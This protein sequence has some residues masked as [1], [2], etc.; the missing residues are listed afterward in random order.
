M[1]VDIKSTKQETGSRTQNSTTTLD[2]SISNGRSECLESFENCGNRQPEIERATSDGSFSGPFVPPKGTTPA[3]TVSLM[4]SSACNLKPKSPRKK[5]DLKRKSVTDEE[6]NKNK[7]FV[8]EL[9]GG[10]SLINKL[11]KYGTESKKQPFMVA[12]QLTFEDS[13]IVNNGND[14]EDE[15]TDSTISDEEMV[16]TNKTFSQ[17]FDFQNGTSATRSA[18]RVGTNRRTENLVSRTPTPTQQKYKKGDIVQ[19]PNGIRKKFNGKQWRRL[20]SREGCNKESQRRGYC[21]RHLSQKGRSIKTTSIPG[22]KKGKIKGKG[23]IEW[24][25]GGDSEG[26]VEE[27]CSPKGDKANIGNK[28]VEAAAMLM[29]LSSSRCATPFSNPTTPLPLSPNIGHSQS[30]S[31]FSYYN[32]GHS[33][34]APNPNR[35][36]TPVRNWM[37]SAVPRS[38]RSSSTELLSPFCPVTS[39]VS[40]AVSPDS[41]IHCRDDSASLT[42]N[43]P[44]LISPLPSLSPH[45]PTKRTFSPISPPAGSKRAFSP[46]PPTPPAI[47]SKQSFSPLPFA[48]SAITPPKAK[49]SRVTLYSPVPQTLPVT[50]ISTFQPVSQSSSTKKSQESSGKQKRD[51]QGIKSKVSAIAAVDKLNLSC[52]A[53]LETDFSHPDDKTIN[54]SVVS[55]ETCPA[56]Q[57]EIKQSLHLPETQVTAVHIAVYPWQTLL[58]SLISAPSPVECGR[59]SDKIM[60]QPSLNISENSCSYQDKQVVLTSINKE[61]SEIVP[62]ADENSFAVD[63]RDRNNSQSDETKADEEV[64]IN[65]AGAVTSKSVRPAN[66]DDGKTTPKVGVI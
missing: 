42:S 37:Q 27:E 44:S 9:N 56:Q 28:E 38:G 34:S 22:H 52:K 2:T 16:N 13:D 62:S 61:S 49:A 41:G 20:C 54:C 47:S 26:S 57:I 1:S 46:T 33:N 10:H 12:R 36:G 17:N 23:E 51:M 14:V 8:S 21:S 40:N 15:N 7:K 18:K 30:P 65:L 4:S 60:S 32:Q 25:S 3:V 19:T 6:N 64:A 39:S 11:P 50:S 5:E 29:S 31:P 55:T 48:P 58:P 59:N 35:S 66:D 45:T 53:K 24:E 63:S 43:T